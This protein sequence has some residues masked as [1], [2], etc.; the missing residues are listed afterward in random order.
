MRALLLALACCAPCRAY[1]RVVRIAPDGTETS[2][3]AKDCKELAPGVNLC[4]ELNIDGKDLR[5]VVNSS[6]VPERCPVKAAKDSLVRMHY[7]ASIDES[8]SAGVPGTVF[9]AVEDFTNTNTVA[10]GQKQINHGL[11]IAVVGMCEGQVAT[12]VV[13]PEL[14]YK[15]DGRAAEGAREAVPP[16][17]TLRYELEL[18]I[19]LQPKQPPNLFRMI[20]RD[21]DGHLDQAEIDAH[22]ARLKRASPPGVVVEQDKDLDGRISWHEFTGPKGT[23][24]DEL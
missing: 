8:S 18:M 3:F 12:L 21:G 7:V 16:D 10:L 5:L 15:A 22:F 9:S 20:D 11:D 2:E 4:D 23:G 24:K 17:A 6:F 19:V 1:V 13:P 14:G